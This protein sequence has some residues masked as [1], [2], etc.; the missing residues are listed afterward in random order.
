[1]IYTTFLTIDYV[2]KVT[3]TTIFFMTA[4]GHTTLQELIIAPNKTTINPSIDSVLTEQ[5]SSEWSAL[6][7]HDQTKILAT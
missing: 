5:W 2:V 7:G 4:Y 1:M 6:K 3:I